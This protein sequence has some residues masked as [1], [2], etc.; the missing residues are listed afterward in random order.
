MTQGLELPN[1]SLVASTNLLPTHKLPSS[2]PTTLRPSHHFL[3][4]EDTT[5]QARM[6]STT[7]TIVRVGP[8]IFCNT[9][10]AS[11]TITNS[12]PIQICTSNNYF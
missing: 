7:G 12:V 2:P 4:A 6:R 3:E 5:G 8:R 1:L 9:L 11:T 10:P